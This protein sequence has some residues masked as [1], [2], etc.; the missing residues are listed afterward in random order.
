MP[1]AGER[2]PVALVRRDPS[3]RTKNDKTERKIERKTCGKRCLRVAA[4]CLCSVDASQGRE[5]AF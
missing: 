1:S 2:L 3:I 5:N 4:A